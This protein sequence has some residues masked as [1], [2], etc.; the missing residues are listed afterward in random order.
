MQVCKKKKEDAPTSIKFKMYSKSYNKL[1]NLNIQKA[2]SLY[3]YF[4]SMSLEK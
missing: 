2:E 1:K 4:K 3:L